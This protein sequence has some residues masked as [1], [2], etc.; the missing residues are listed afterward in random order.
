MKQKQKFIGTRSL[1]RTTAMAMAGVMGLS[2]AP[3]HA[4]ANPYD[5][6]NYYTQYATDAPE[7]EGEGEI[8]LDLGG[9]SPELDLDGF[10][11]DLGGGAW[12]GGEYNPTYTG[13]TDYVY[14]H[15]EDEDGNPLFDEDG[16][17]VTERA[18]DEHGNYYRV[19]VNPIIRPVAE[20]EEVH[21]G[22]ART[23]LVDT[24][25]TVAEWQN[26]IDTLGLS[27]G[28]VWGGTNA[29]LTATPYGIRVSGRDAANTGMIWSPEL[30]SRAGGFTGMWD[31]TNENAI[32]DTRHVAEFT[33]LD[34]YG[35]PIAIQSHG[36]NGGTFTDGVLL[37]DANWTGHA[38]NGLAHFT[39]PDAIATTEDFYLTG[40]RIA[41]QPGWNN[42]Q[43]VLASLTSVFDLMASVVGYG[44][45]IHGG[46]ADVP[47]A[48]LGDTVTI[49]AAPGARQSFVNWTV[50]TPATGVILDNANHYTT[51]FTMPDA[52]VV[53]TANM[54]TGPLNFNLRSLLPSTANPGV[55]LPDTGGVLGQMGGS[56]QQ[57][58]VGGYT[59]LE[60]TGGGQS[61]HGI[62]ISTLSPGDT[63]RISG[64]VSP[65]ETVPA[66]PNLSPHNANHNSIVNIPA[67]GIAPGDYFVL[68]HPI[69]EQDLLHHADGRL[70]LGTT[71][72][73]TA[74]LF[75][76]NIELVD[77]DTS[78]STFV[79]VPDFTDPMLGF[80]TNL[81]PYVTATVD[82]NFF[83]GGAVDA[84]ARVELYV[85]APAGR[86]FA[87]WIL[88]PQVELVYGTVNTPSIGFYMPDA[89]IEINVNW[90]FH[91]SPGWTGNTIGELFN[92][93]ALFASFPLGELVD[94]S[95]TAVQVGPNAGPSGAFLG[96]TASG[97]VV[98][99]V[100]EEEGQRMLQV[101]R[102]AAND[103]YGWTGLGINLHYQNR[104]REGD[105]ITVS[106]VAMGGSTMRI[107]ASA[108][109]WGSVATAPVT[110][111]NPH[112]S[113]SF[114]LNQRAMT[115]ASGLDS[116]RIN[117]AAV[118]MGFYITEISIYRPVEPGTVAEN[119][120]MISDAELYD[121]LNAAGVP[122]GARLEMERIVAELRD[123]FFG[124]PVTLAGEPGYL[125]NGHLTV[126]FSIGYLHENR[127]T[128]RPSADAVSLVHRFLLAE[129][130]VSHGVGINLRN[131]EWRA[132][133]MPGA[134]RGFVRDMTF[135]IYLTANPEVL[136]GTGQV[137]VHIQPNGIPTFSTIV[138]AS[139]NNWV[140]P[141]I[142]NPVSLS[143]N[144]AGGTLP[145]RDS[146]T[147]QMGLSVQQQFASGIAAQIAQPY[148][149]G[150]IFRGWYIGDNRLTLNT[151][152]ASDLTA[153]ARWS[154]RPGFEL[155]EDYVEYV[156]D[157]GEQFVFDS[158]I[159]VSDFADGRPWQLQDAGNPTESVV[160]ING[161]PALRLGGR[162]ANW[163]SVDLHRDSLN[164]QAGDVVTVSGRSV[165]FPEGGQI[166]IGSVNSPWEDVPGGRIDVTGDQDWSITFVVTDA[167]ATAPNFV[168]F[169]IHTNDVAGHNDF[170]ITNILVGRP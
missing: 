161:A 16:N 102:S 84:G 54:E 47:S 94:S 154:V 18:R 125:P 78:L 68:E 165:G 22:I 40:I 148:R 61:Y 37:T 74:S 90:N 13:E 91:A 29:T 19:P 138:P 89:L 20:P 21:I 163:H 62:A 72:P 155:P 23:N 82:G 60:M 167:L 53:I 143:F 56:L 10:A 95:G 5:I 115:P 135:D 71:S 134:W 113:L 39:T 132:V 27:G 142:T 85:S 25:H 137:R 2:V 118:T 31:P 123:D 170:I 93:A 110:A 100:E 156:P 139:T 99:V 11:P 130:G 70:T 146:L 140:R 141:A 77:A 160:Q 112:F 131:V 97:P 26:V 136:V 50:N 9:I 88:P 7:T 83:T 129:L 15:A 152:L 119:V 73:H 64:R 51:T 166:V 38:E 52:P 43:P 151:S 149:E 48:Q 1:K 168:R 42:N 133:A 63:V 169:R 44:I 76:F 104:L 105:I 41:T 107:E 86:D 144:A 8:D 59:F 69:T 36:G 30:I 65:L 75:I 3:L 109:P 127:H 157:V 108:Q 12:I 106:G 81:E 34:A 114:T 14:I 122:V 32:H 17:P 4:L 103:P 57:V 87:G 46:T 66:R 101:D 58:S 6:N 128:M 159:F 33:F 153:V 79:P 117:A 126:P 150:H 116:I 124:S 98:S 67:P 96:T 24:G 80:H 162:S 164:M 92:S 35:E 158:I 45:T 55:G 120:G 121:R 147:V 145:G 111:A 28:N 49:T